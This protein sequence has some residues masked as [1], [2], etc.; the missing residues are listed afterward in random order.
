MNLNDAIILAKGNLVVVFLL[1]I[2]LIAGL[3]GDILHTLMNLYNK[4]CHFC[5]EQL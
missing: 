5:L 3:F 1:L 4:L 2:A